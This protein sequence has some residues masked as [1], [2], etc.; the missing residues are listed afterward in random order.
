MCAELQ[1]LSSN[2]RAKQPQHPKLCHR[3]SDADLQ[4]ATMSEE[5]CSSASPIVL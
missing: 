2:S 5:C 3:V 4:F 1:A